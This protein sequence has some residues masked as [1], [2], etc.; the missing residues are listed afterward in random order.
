MS[1]G[2]GF[3]GQRISTQRFLK[4]SVNV[5]SGAQRLHR[6]KQMD[7]Q[8][9]S[10]DQS[11]G[12]RLGLMVRRSV[13]SD[14]DLEVVEYFAYLHDCQRWS[15]E[16]IGYT[17]REP[18]NLPSRTGSCLISANHNSRNWSARWRVIPS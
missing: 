15:E 9:D 5:C 10:W 6:G 4:V 18:R 14:A 17:A 16:Q 1:V 12:T 3:V 8:P 11:L 7:L 13:G 2:Y